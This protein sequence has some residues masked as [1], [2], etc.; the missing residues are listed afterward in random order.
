MTAAQMN[1]NGPHRRYILSRNMPAWGDSSA[2]NSKNNSNNS[3]NSNNNTY[4]RRRDLLKLGLSNTN[5]NNFVS[6]A[7][8]R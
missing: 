2:T 5:N 6:F 8:R 4:K 1:A 7:Q 3:N